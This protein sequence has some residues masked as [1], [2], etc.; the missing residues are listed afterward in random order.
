M[1]KVGSNN[2]SEEAEPRKRVGGVGGEEE[3]EQLRVA[4]EEGNRRLIGEVAGS[5][6]GDD[7]KEEES[8]GNRRGIETPKKLH[9]GLSKSLE[10]SLFYILLYSPVSPLGNKSS[11]VQMEQAG[12]IAVAGL[13]KPKQGEPRVNESF[14]TGETGDTWETGGKV[15]NG[16]HRADCDYS[17]KA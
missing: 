5:R 13:E 4:D 1:A 2:G 7:I 12:D 14:I 9:L 10:V 8:R 17:F 11:G 15:D 6:R 3:L 16:G